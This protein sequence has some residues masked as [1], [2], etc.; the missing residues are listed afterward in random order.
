MEI[1]L[2]EPRSNEESLPLPGTPWKIVIL[3]GGWVFAGQT[4]DAGDR[5]EIRDA[6]NIRR[7]GTTHGLGELARC[8][9]RPDTVTDD[10]GVIFA[11]KTAII[12]TIE[13]EED[14]W[15]G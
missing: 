4:F 11:Q 1:S 13:C 6:K 8:G 14:Q 3:A 10:Y 2:N 5:I 9:A 12:A 7:W 15:G